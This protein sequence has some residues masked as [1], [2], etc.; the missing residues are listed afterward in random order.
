[1]PDVHRFIR[2]QQPD[3]SSLIVRYN[4]AM[5]IVVLLIVV[6]GAVAA[7]IW[8]QTRAQGRWGIGS[9]AGT[10]CPRCGTHLPTIRKPAST[11][12]MLWG[13]WTCPKCGCK[14]DK[15]GHEAPS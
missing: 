6:L 2:S 15:Y 4:R 3:A 11:G 7:I 13:G 14:V 5:G 1:M 9:F 8:R 12:E 10:N